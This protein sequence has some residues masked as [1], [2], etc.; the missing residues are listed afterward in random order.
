MRSTF[1]TGS[2]RAV[3][4]TAVAFFALAGC[5]ADTDSDPATS[6]SSATSSTTSETTPTAESTP[7]LETAEPELP[8]FEEPTTTT[9][10]YT[11]PPPPPEPAY[12]PPPQEPEYVP[13][14]ADNGGGGQAFANCSEARAAGAAPVYRGDPG[15]GSHL[16][17]DDD[18]VGCE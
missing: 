13:P 14:P 15:Y 4:L 12:T 9:T 8:Q 3:G 16:D 17:R 6:S 2:R 18:G 5:G 10:V 7:E 11:P 1:F